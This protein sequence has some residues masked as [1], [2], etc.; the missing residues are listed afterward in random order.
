M[1]I[2]AAE[3]CEACRKQLH[4]SAIFDVPDEV[5][6][7]QPAANLDSVTTVLDDASKSEH[8]FRQLGRYQIV[9][10]LGRGNMAVTYRAW[11]PRLGRPVA[12]KV[13]HEQSSSWTE[14]LLR[15]ART[16]AE[17]DV[18]GV[19]TVH[20]ADVD[21]ETGLTFLVSRLIT[22]QTLEQYIAEQKRLPLENAVDLLDQLLQIL[23][24]VHPM[25]IVHRDIKPMNLMIDQAG[26]LVL[27]DFGIARVVEN[28]PS[29][30]TETSG[31]PH[32]MPPEQKLGQD[33]RDPRTDLYAAGVCFYDMLVGV[34]DEAKA[35]YRANHDFASALAAQ[36]IV[37]SNVVDLIAQATHPDRSQRFQSADAFHQALTSLITEKEA[38]THSTLV[39]NPDKASAINLASALS[40]QTLFIQHIKAS[41]GSISDWYVPTQ[42]KPIRASLR[43][44][45]KLNRN[46]AFKHRANRLLEESRWQVE[47]KSLLS[48]QQH[49][50]IT[51]ALV[52][53]Y[54]QFL[55]HDEIT[56]PID[57]L[58]LQQ[59]IAEIVQL[60][61]TKTKARS[62]AHLL[63]IASP[64]GF[65]PS[66]LQWARQIN[67]GQG[68]AAALIP[69]ITDAP[70]YRSDPWLDGLFA[71]WPNAAQNN[72]QWQAIITWA[73]NM[74]EHRPALSAEDLQAEFQLSEVQAQERLQELANLSEFTSEKI[75][76]IGMVLRK[77]ESPLG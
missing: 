52:T 58:H 54:D 45:D 4:D 2:E 5:A 74:L 39:S 28:D 44:L 3:Q 70:V 12:I 30:L 67:L 43:S 23:G 36:N 20:D 15:E 56:G 22:G 33:A 6:W 19:V 37:P 40:M 21:P 24:G 51:A 68:T 57:E 60:T 31:S 46:F 73:R 27:L 63:L 59:R 26:R 18:P 8:A 13:P 65:T 34:S 55:Q 42:A 14:R 11:D 76:P 61:Q 17:I 32:Y 16:M 49:L 53:H 1:A 47:T 9:N 35:H 7:L 38:T 62:K 29:Q 75:D 41:L 77:I 69:S 64:T 72:S 71:Q 66:A 50:L 48:S 25:G 10:E